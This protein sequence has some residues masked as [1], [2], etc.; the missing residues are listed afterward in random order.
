MIYEEFTQSRAATI[1]RVLDA[2]GID[3]PEPAGQKPM[4]RQAD[5]LSRDWV[6]RYRQESERSVSA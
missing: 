2:L 5:D 1:G 3:P 6:E 4:K